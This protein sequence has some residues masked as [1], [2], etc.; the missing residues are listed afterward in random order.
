MRL[1]RGQNRKETYF[2]K[3]L[4]LELGGILNRNKDIKAK[5]AEFSYRK[6]GWYWRRDVVS[7]GNGSVEPSSKG[8]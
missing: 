3:C 7:A 4:H 1:S 8:R 6:C 5:D 2:H